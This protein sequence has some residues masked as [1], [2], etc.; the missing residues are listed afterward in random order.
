MMLQSLIPS[1]EHAEEADLCAEMAG[2]ASD[3]QQGFGTGVKQQLVDQSFVLEC[4]WSEFPRQCENYVHVAGGQQFLLASLE[5][6]QTGVALAPWTM[7]VTARVIRDGGMSAFRALIAMSAQRGGAAAH[8]G[9]QHLLVLS[10]NPLAIALH[11][12]LPCKAND[13]GH[14]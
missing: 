8:D 11:E 13:V 10:G 1:M 3:L 9:E 6:A 2:I 12:R 14:L 7:S 4:E 5:P